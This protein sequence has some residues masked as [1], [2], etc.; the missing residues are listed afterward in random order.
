MGLRLFLAEFLSSLFPNGSPPRMLFTLAHELGHLLSHHDLSEDFAFLGQGFACRVGVS[1][2]AQGRRTIRARICFVPAH[3]CGW[4]RDRSEENPG[5]AHIKGGETLGDVEV[6]FL[7]R[8]YGVS[9]AA[10]A[11]RCED[12]RLFTPRGRPIVGRVPEEE[13]R[14]RRKASR[15]SLAARAPFC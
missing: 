9:F 2:G 12:L 11:K 8:I 4:S 5:A 6:L 15:I 14:Q 7:S 1:V 13:I 3:A 10:A